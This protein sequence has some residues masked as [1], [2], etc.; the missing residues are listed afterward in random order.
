VFAYPDNVPLRTCSAED[1]IVFKAF[2]ARGQDWVDVERIIIR[3]AAG[4]DWALIRRQLEP[5]A[6]AK[7]APEIMDRLERLRQSLAA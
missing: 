4:L 3:Q 5:L 2:A 7:E 1:L 6:Q